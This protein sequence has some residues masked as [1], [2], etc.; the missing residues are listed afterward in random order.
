MYVPSSSGRDPS[1]TRVASAWL[2]GYPPV[3]CLY[4]LRAFLTDRGVGKIAK[5]DLR[6][7]ISELLT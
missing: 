3:A 6:T 1:V 5:N 2:A 4:E 7:R